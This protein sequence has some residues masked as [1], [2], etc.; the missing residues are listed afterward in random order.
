MDQFFSQLHTNC[1]SAEPHLPHLA[2]HLGTKTLPGPKGEHMS[3]LRL[4]R[5][6]WIP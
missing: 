1:Q 2:S 5:N 6:F 3:A 4:L